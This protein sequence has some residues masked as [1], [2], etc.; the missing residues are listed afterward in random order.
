M[1]VADAHTYTVGDGEWVVHNDCNVAIRLVS[2]KLPKRFGSGKTSGFLLDSRGNVIGDMITSGRNRFSFDHTLVRG[3]N[4]AFQIQDHVEAQVAG[5]MRENNITDAILVLNNHPCSG[6]PY[7]C[8]ALLE[9]ML[10][11]GAN[12]RVIVPEGFDA[13][14]VFEQIYRGIVD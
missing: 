12:L 13:R 4:R 11:P 6:K 5:I 7:T 3:E 10:L 8:N 2:S 9:R 1:T 14:G